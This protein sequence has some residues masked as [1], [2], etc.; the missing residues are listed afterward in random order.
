MSLSEVPDEVVQYIL[1]F[2]PRCELIVIEHVSK[3]FGSYIDERPF[4]IPKTI[5][6]ASV[7][8]LAWALRSGLELTSINKWKVIQHGNLDIFRI[9]AKIIPWKYNGDLLWEA[10]HHGQPHIAKEIID[11]LKD[12]ELDNSLTWW[13]AY[14]D[15]I[16]TLK[17]LR[18]RKCP[19][20]KKR[21]LHNSRL[22]PEMFALI[23][24]GELD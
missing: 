17:V 23:E 14:F 6:Y 11:Q 1:T 21:C 15:E 19:W 10:M 9:L 13:A 5:A 8:R 12:G 7:E 18:A 4:F 22:Y 3:K 24:S 20:N 2:L 16:E